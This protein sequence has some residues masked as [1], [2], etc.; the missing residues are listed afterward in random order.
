MPGKPADAEQ[1]FRRAVSIAR[2]SLP[3][4]HPFVTTSQQNLRDFCAARGKPVESSPP[5]E[6]KAA[7]RPSRPEAETLVQA[8][9]SAAVAVPPVAAAAQAVP[10]AEPVEDPEATSKK[11]FTRV[12]LGALGPIA[13]LMI[14]AGLIFGFNL[15][16]YFAAG[17]V[18]LAGG[19]ILYDTS[20]VLLHYPKDRYVGAALQLFA[21][22]ALLFWYVLR[23]AMALMSRD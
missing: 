18:A 12:A 2:T 11:F 19:M 5:P 23:I 9:V 1:Y 7:P 20:N 15:G 17:M 3:P 6:P 4:D 21:S 22:L 14:V 8:E 13:M 16:L 10:V